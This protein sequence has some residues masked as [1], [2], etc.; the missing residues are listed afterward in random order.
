MSIDS[1]DEEAT[2][3]LRKE[4]QVKEVSRGIGFNDTILVAYTCRRQ[5]VVVTYEAK[6]LKYTGHQWNK[7]IPLVCEEQGV[8]CITFVEM[9]KEIEE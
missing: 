1:A 7:K 2:L 6:Q 5:H 8:K 4:Y 9:L 3:L